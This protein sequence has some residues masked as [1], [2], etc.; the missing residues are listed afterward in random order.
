[1]DTLEAIK[2]RHSSR[3]FLP[4]PVDRAIIED[5]IDC[6]RVAPSGRGEQPWEFV[7]ITDQTT[8]ERI[9]TLTSYGRF[10]AHAPV[11]IAVFCRPT[12]YY[13][14]DGAAAME[15]ILLA[16]TAYGLGSCW[17]AGDKK[18]YVPDVR[19]LLSVP[20]TYKLVSLAAIGYAKPVE[21]RAKRPMEEVLHWEK[22]GNH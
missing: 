6:A 14:E 2:S 17:I 1:M 22:F 13:L 5:L 18:D 20:E 19:A 10:I 3:E 9:A 16:A 8:R 7:V 15:N 21:P 4:Q 12:T 11:C